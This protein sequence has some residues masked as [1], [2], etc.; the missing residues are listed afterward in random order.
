MEK[1]PIH[2]IFLTDFDP[3]IS[4]P[5]KKCGLDI[6]DERLVLPFMVT[7]VISSVGIVS[8]HKYFDWGLYYIPLDILMILIEYIL[9]FPI[10][11]RY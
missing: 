4:I 6:V 8:L 10:K 3:P 2:N 7:I 1:I 5:C 9:L 11:K